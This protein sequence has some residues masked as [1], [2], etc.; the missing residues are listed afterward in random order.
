[1]TLQLLSILSVYCLWR[2]NFINIKTVH[3]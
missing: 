2:I 1:M 3:P